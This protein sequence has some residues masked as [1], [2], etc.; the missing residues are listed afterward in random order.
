M[1]N[2]VAMRPKPDLEDQAWEQLVLWLVSKGYCADFI[3]TACEEHEKRVIEAARGA[4][5]HAKKDDDID[6]LLTT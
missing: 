2:V 6:L 1:N 4:W 5:G 3:R